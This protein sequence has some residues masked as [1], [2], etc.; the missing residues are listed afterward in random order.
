MCKDLTKRI[1]EHNRGK[2]RST[3][4]GIPWEIVLTEDFYNRRDAYKRERQ[5]KRYKGGQAFK[6]LLRKG[7]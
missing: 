6:E 5:I 1:T 4:N 7:G 2:T 3:K